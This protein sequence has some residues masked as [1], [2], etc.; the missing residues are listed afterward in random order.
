MEVE[1][2]VDA[3]L[4]AMI[5]SPIDLFENRLLEVSR[6]LGVGPVMIVQ[7]KPQEVESQLGDVGEVAVVKERLAAPAVADGQVESAP[8]R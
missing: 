2:Q 3:I 6:L 5:D 4:L 8:V 7:G 1:Q